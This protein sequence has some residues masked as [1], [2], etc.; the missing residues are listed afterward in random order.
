MNSF[1]VERVVKIQSAHEKAFCNIESAKT[2]SVVIV[3]RG[4]HRRCN[5]EPPQHKSV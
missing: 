4:F 2:E 3:Q 1:A 5:K